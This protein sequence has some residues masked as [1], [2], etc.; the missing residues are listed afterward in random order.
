MIQRIQTVYLFLTAIVCGLLFFFPFAE[1][2]GQ[3]TIIEYSVLGI[4]EKV[5]SLDPLFNKYFTL[6]LMIV[7]VAMVILPLVA[8]FM[9]KSGYKQLLLIRISFLLNFILLALV[10][11]YYNEKIEAVVDAEPT[12]KLAIFAPLIG[13]L[14]LLLAMRG[15]RKDINLIRSTDRLR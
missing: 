6:P 13:M 11:F 15:V 9:Y 8:I 3:T 1:F 12:Y 10:F 7:A 2:L 4:V 5:P 14:F